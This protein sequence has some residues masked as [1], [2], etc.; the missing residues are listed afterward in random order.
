LHTNPR[1]YGTTPA[2]HALN[3]GIHESCKEM[4]WPLSSGLRIAVTSR[5]SIC[6]LDLCQGM[7]I[8]FKLKVPWI[9]SKRLLKII[10]AGLEYHKDPLMVCLSIL[11]CPCKSCPK[12]THMLAISI[13][14]TP[15]FPTRH[16]DETQPY[17]MPSYI[18]STLCPRLVGTS[19]LTVHNNSASRMYLFSLYFSL[20]S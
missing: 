2:M 13:P 14:Q 8:R 19:Q 6:L 7:Y 9:D 3:I 15:M 18:S 5:V 20:A 4:W 12:S 10:M 11:I 16:P 1:N 17:R